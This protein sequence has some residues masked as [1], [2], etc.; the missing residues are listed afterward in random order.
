MPG[1]HVELAVGRLQQDHRGV[2]DDVED[3]PVEVR[4]LAALGVGLP[5]VGVAFDDH[6]AALAHGVHHLP[7][8]QGR[9]VGVGP[10]VGPGEEHRHPVL[11]LLLLGQRGD[12][13]VG[14]PVEPLEIVARHRGERALERQVV[15]QQPGRLRKAEAYGLVVD[16]TG[17]RRAL[18]GSQ[19]QR[20]PGRIEDGI[21]QHV[22]GEHDVGGGERLAVRPPHPRAQPEGE[23]PGVRR[24]LERLGDVGDR[25][26]PAGIPAQQG[27]VAHSTTEPG[28]VGRAEQRGPPR[29][30]V[31]SGALDRPDDERD[32]RNAVRE[33]RQL[34]LHDL[35]G[36]ARRLLRGRTRRVLSFLTAALPGGGVGGQ[37]VASA[38]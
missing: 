5:V 2:G 20:K 38:G 28:G 21:G 1:V 33:R 31:A 37:Q 17:L 8:T 12:L 36:Q 11:E 6:P 9:Q 7:G 27:F 16:P 23:L 29:T 15:D 10:V 13:R 14:L 34:S 18:A 30:S 19:V 26:R 24:H 4:Q 35:L 3:H 32:L 22:D 25:L